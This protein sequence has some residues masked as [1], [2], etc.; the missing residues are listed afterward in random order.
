MTFMSPSTDWWVVAIT[1]ITFEKVGFHCIHIYCIYTSSNSADANKTG[2][3]KH[4][5]A[6]NRHRI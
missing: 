3:F 6:C 5:L 1:C 4:T 2:T